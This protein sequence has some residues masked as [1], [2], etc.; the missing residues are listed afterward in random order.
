MEA[1]K[2]VR[3]ETSIAKA[4][5]LATVLRGHNGERHLIALQDFPDPD[6]LSSAWAHK[7]ISANYDIICDIAY[8]GKISHQEN[9]A[10]VQLTNMELIGP[11]EK[12]RPEIYSGLVL[13]DNQ[14][15]TAGL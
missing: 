7:L 3:S 8:V 1:Q 12:L 11:S 5:E 9:R 2:R 15:T 10:L 13:V 6:A 14:G 4:Q